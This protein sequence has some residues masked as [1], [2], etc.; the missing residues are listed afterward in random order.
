[1]IFV[2]SADGGLLYLFLKR[3][4]VGDIRFYPTNAMIQKA[5]RE[6][7]YCDTKA[8]CVAVPPDEIIKKI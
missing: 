8:D 1:L 5:A 4:V 7:N 6:L 2:I 3:T